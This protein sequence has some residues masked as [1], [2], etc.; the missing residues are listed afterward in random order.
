MRRSLRRRPTIAMDAS[1][2]DAKTCSP[3]STSV[4]PASIDNAEAPAARIAWIVA[5]PITGTSNRMSWFGFATFTIR[6]AGTGETPGAADHLVGALHRLD[7]DDRLVLDRDGLPDVERRNRVGHAVA[8]FEVRALLVR[9]RARA[10]H[11]FTCEQRRQERCRIQQLDPLV[12]HALQPP[13]R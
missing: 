13:P 10:Q 1:F 5:R 2:A 3:S 9:R 12:A 6:D 7:R 8:E 4:L 11:A